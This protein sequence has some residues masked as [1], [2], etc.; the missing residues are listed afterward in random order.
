MSVQLQER[1]TETQKRRTDFQRRIGEPVATAKKPAGRKIN[2]GPIERAIS[3]A[4]GT[5]LLWNAT[6]ARKKRLMELASATRLDLSRAVRPMPPLP[7]ARNRPLG[8]TP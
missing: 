5:A 3:V 6:G 4:A 7:P 2:V 8:K 1:D